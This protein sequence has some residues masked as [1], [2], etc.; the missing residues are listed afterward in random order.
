MSPLSIRVALS[1]GAA[2]LLA[3][4]PFSANAAPAVPLAD[5]PPACH[6]AAA[7]SEAGS[8]TP[9]AHAGHTAHAEHGAMIDHS[10]HRVP[11]PPASE[12]GTTEVIATGGLTIPDFELLDQEGRVVHFYSDLVQNRVVAMNFVFTT[13]TT[14]CP[15]M[16]A[17]FA[18]LQA[19]L[20]ERAAEEV[21]LISISVDPMTD[22]PDRLKA[23]AERFRSDQE[24]GPRWTLVTGDKARIDTLLKAL[25]VFTPD[26]EDHSPIVLVGNDAAGRWMRAYGLAPAT[27]L[28]ALL[29]EMDGDAAHQGEQKSRLAST[30]GG[31]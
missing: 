4:L 6:G 16:G 5:E 26:S 19:L 28:D 25:K 31:R 23:W 8:A 7:A 27:Q 18:R 1:A 3:V 20:G 21:E 29:A 22:T 30:G 15:P 13:C 11:D 14:I 9:A 17:N 24:G 12:Q 10:R 2:L